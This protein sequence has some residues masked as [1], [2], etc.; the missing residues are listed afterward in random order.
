MNSKRVFLLLFF[1]FTGI[2]QLLACTNLLVTKGASADGSTMLVY[3][4]DGEWLYRIDKTNAASY[5]PGDSIAFTSR[6]GVSGKIAQAKQTYAVLGFQMNEHQVAIGETTFTGREELWN[7]SGGYLEYWHF[8]TLALQRS[9]SAREA[10][11]V[12]TTLAENYGYGSEGESFS[13]CDPDEAWIL[14]MCGVGDG[15]KG[16]VWVAVKIPD[17]H[18][19]AHANMARIG[20]FPLDD[21][22]TCLYSENVISFATEKGYYDPSSGEP[23]HFNL[24]YNPPTPDRLKYCETRVWSLFRRSAPSLELTSDYHRGVVGAERYPLSVK[25]DHKLTLADVMSL[26]RDHYEGTEYDMTKGLTAGP[27]GNPN[28]IRPLNWSVDSVDYSWERPI[29]TYNTAFSYI[30]QLR[31]WLP[32]DI[33]GIAWFGEDDTYF[34]CYMPLYAS[35]TEIPSPLSSGDINKYSPESAWWIFNFVSN[36][37]NIRYNEMIKDVQAL[38]RS[39]EEKFISEQDSIEG[40]AASLSGESRRAFINNYVN[41]C[42]LLV[43]EEWKELGNLL[44]TKYNDGYIKDSKGVIREK[45]YP[46]KWKGTIIRYEGENHRIPDSGNEYKPF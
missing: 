21:P 46:E 2:H 26:V 28:R 38:Q 15:K 44:I 23:F 30:A 11:Q 33:G 24:A 29:S 7:K 25:P 43:C 18:I 40:I 3:T 20:H 17:G 12:I 36:I 16:A 14:E 9:R 31:G 37:A 19:A 6:Y 22:E 45:G 10:I 27:F 1:I 13:I 34:T 4:N 8:M 42:C 5:S 41:D 35:I 32:D 39:L